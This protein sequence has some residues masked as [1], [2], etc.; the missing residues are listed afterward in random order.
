MDVSIKT[1]LKQKQ[2]K[3]SGLGTKTSLLRIFGSDDNPLKVMNST[4]WILTL[5]CY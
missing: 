5:K 3:F 2:L 4:A 1:L